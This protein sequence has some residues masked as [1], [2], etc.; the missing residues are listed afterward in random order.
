LFPPQIAN[1]A[2]FHRK[3]ELSGF[4]GSPSQL[5]RIIG[6]LLTSHMTYTNCYMF[7]FYVF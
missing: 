1:V 2:Y 7:Q 5:I 3:I 4:F 6:V